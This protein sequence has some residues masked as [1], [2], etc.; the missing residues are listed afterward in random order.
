M[1]SARRWRFGHGEVF[2]V[3]FALSFAAALLAA[4]AWLF[5]ALAVVRAVAGSPWPALAPGRPRGLAVLAVGALL[6]NW[7]FLVIANRP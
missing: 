2:A 4:L 6:A 1:V 7:A 5:A 3:L